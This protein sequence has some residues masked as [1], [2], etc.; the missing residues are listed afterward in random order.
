MTHI[1]YL[2]K[3]RTSRKSGKNFIYRR[4]LQ[5]VLEE[6]SQKNPVS[7]DTI[8]DEKMARDL[9]ENEPGIFPFS[10]TSR[11]TRY[12]DS[13]FDRKTSNGK[14][15]FLDIDSVQLAEMLFEDAEVLQSLFPPLLA[16]WYSLRGKIHMAVRCDWT[17]YS[18]Y[19]AAWIGISAR[20]SE[21]ISGLYGR[22]CAKL[23]DTAN[24]GC[25]AVP[26]HC[27]SACY[28]KGYRWFGDEIFFASE[29]VFIPD[30]ALVSQNTWRDTPKTY[31]VKDA[32]FSDDEAKR[33]WH[34][35]SVS[36]WVKWAEKNRNWEYTTENKQL[37]YKEIYI[38]PGV[39]PNWEYETIRY[40]ENDGDYYTIKFERKGYKQ[41]RLLD[42]RKR[43]LS[44]VAKYAASVLRVTF[45]ECLY[46]TSMFYIR[47]CEPWYACEVE[48]PE[49]LIQSKVE[50][51]YANRVRNMNTLDGLKDTR[52]ILVNPNFDEC[53]YYS[54]R[55]QASMA[56]AVKAQLRVNKLKECYCDGDTLD[57]LTEKMAQWYPNITETTVYRVAK[58]A[59]VKI[60]T[61]KNYRSKYGDRYKGRY[62]G[63]YD[64]I[65]AYDSNGKRTRI[66]RELIDNQRYFDSKKSYTAYAE[67]LDA[68]QTGSVLP[69]VQMG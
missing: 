16:V 68:G 30:P 44:A 1:A 14:V 40:C 64:Y 9:K 34:R 29:N 54:G 62:A 47:N 28:T 6:Q 53:Y 66:K 45:E 10:L 57:S 8:N 43:W 13:L 33:K 18:C 58:M 4:S 15:V 17:G 50:D 23:F 24:D 3:V 31:A 26:N 22:A 49:A 46:I 55:R 65:N 61:T 52:E 2:Q 42:G 35:G 48:D 21:I 20:L 7:E 32:L 38:E 59:N 27:V 56:K 69:V 60:N 63:R 36:S 67:S 11:Q 5:S 12:T 19:A 25:M 37:T 41:R 51:A 39:N